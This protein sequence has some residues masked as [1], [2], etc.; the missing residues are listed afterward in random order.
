MGDRR[1]FGSYFGHGAGL[2]STRMGGGGVAMG[3]SDF[4]TDPKDGEA[5]LLFLADR[6]ELGKL[7]PD[8][9]ANQAEH[10]S[11]RAFDG[12]AAPRFVNYVMDGINQTNSFLQDIFPMEQINGL[13][14]EFQEISFNSDF[15]D[16]HAP[17]VPDRRMTMSE[18]NGK[19]FLGCYGKVAMAIWGF[20]RTPA[21]QKMWL[22]Q[23]AQIM[24]A[25]VR[26]IRAMQA[27]ELMSAPEYM[28]PGHKGSKF[29]VGM[30]T[31]EL[32]NL[33]RREAGQF[34]ILQKS[35]SGIKQAIAICKGIL[36]QRQVGTAPK[37]VI[38]GSFTEGISAGPGYETMHTAAIDTRVSSTR[39][40]SFDPLTRSHKV[41]VA[42][43]S[44][45]NHFFDWPADRYSTA[46]AF[47][48]M[49]DGN[50][51]SFFDVKLRELVEA[52]GL[53]DFS[54]EGAPLT[55]GIGMPFFA[56]FGKTWG[57]Y[58]ENV[59]LR[60]RF[61]ARIKTVAGGGNPD[62]NA[63]QRLAT[64]VRILNALNLRII[65]TDADALAE[66]LLNEIGL[67]PAPAAGVV[68]PVNRAPAFDA[69]RDAFLRHFVG[70]D[71]AAVAFRHA[72]R[73]P[74]GGVAVPA[75]VN[76]IDVA[77]VRAAID[78]TGL[79]EFLL[80]FVRNDPRIFGAVGRNGLMHLFAQAVP[81]PADL[82]RQRALIQA[83]R[84][85]INV[86]AAVPSFENPIQ[87]VE[88]EIR[89]PAD[90]HV[91]ADTRTIAEK[92]GALRMDLSE[93]VLVQCAA[94][95]LV[96]S[97]ARGAVAYVAAA[98]PTIA[99]DA[100]LRIG[101]AAP[102]LGGDAA[103]APKIISDATARGLAY[104][105]AVSRIKDHADRI[106]ALPAPTD[107]Q[108][109]L[110][111][112]LNTLVY[113]MLTVMGRNPGKYATLLNELSLRLSGNGAA[114]VPVP[115]AAAGDVFFGTKE[116]SLREITRKINE[117]FGWVEGQEPGANA[118]VAALLAR[119]E[120]DAEIWIVPAGVVGPRPAVGADRFIAPRAYI[121][122]EAD[123]RN[124]VDAVFVAGNVAQIGQ[125]LNRIDE[126]L[127]E[128]LMKMPITN[129]QILM[130]LLDNNVPIPFSWIIA[131]PDRTV[132]AS[133]MIMAVGGG[134]L[135]RTYYN[136]PAADIG[137][138]AAHESFTLHFQVRVQP[139][140]TNHENFVRIHGVHV[141]H[142]VGGWG[143]RF[144]MHTEKNREIYSSRTHIE[145]SHP[146]MF[147]FACPPTDRLDELDIFNLAGPL[148]GNKNHPDP[149]LLP[150]SAC[151]IY[152]SYWRM[153]GHANL[154][155][156][157]KL[158]EGRT[159]SP[160]EMMN[161]TIVTRD[162]IVENECKGE[163]GWALTRATQSN[164]HLGETNIGCSR[165]FEAGMQ[166]RKYVVTG[167]A[168]DQFS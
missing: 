157:A 127:M 98:A 163:G 70:R 71:D 63:R 37:Y 86:V 4:F 85:N 95:A 65:H 74:A 33:L 137:S 117:V 61:M 126:I 25:T 11:Y 148:N 134:A 31:L 109:R 73:I 57:Q 12:V 68:A 46:A 131:R 150:F 83:Q 92:F 47:K 88:D 78:A 16:R 152:A 159:V 118:A 103:N 111:T 9:P 40:V 110:K 28:P 72:L 51:D 22:A 145:A 125:N 75:N 41:G 128:A 91:A 120:G 93:G 124:L 21:G 60:D 166:G 138:S 20:H 161:G 140:I 154:T 62:N 119:A 155:L 30:D 3:A 23:L 17:R 50:T 27:H 76:N 43:A 56:K 96:D 34:A 64:A 116:P 162:F 54:R 129:G 123:I 2:L 8:H 139:V 104:L 165:V 112:K 59:G 106:A 97:T 141:S 81:V 5:P 102:V 44:D 32:Q 55:E 53:F 6:K 13:S 52:C 84:P 167:P 135:G 94:T 69:L 147:A 113:V 133:S 7:G 80:D 156:R 115:P 160:Q 153:N 14:I 158:E 108:V 26:T 10:Q 18:R 49:Y 100:R 24:H 58:L 164:G 122:V 39:T 132:L 29:Q 90:A 107:V 1:D 121:N 35:P 48:R 105:L 36:N 130:V 45:G 151:L 77:Y 42:A 101:G 66:Q 38:L 19:V 82:A 99:S 143:R 89:V 168:I 67:G 149:S 114:V 136:Q 87:V 15:L 146:S 142:V 144:W 79:S